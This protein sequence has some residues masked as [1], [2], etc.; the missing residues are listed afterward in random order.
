MNR[1]EVMRWLVGAAGLAAARPVLAQVPRR[2]RIRRV[3]IL[4]IS[5]QS[6]PDGRARLS[7]FLNAMKSMGWIDGRNI[8]YEYR[9]GASNAG[10]AAALAAELIASAPEVILV[11]G[12]PGVSALQKATRTIPV[13]FVVVTDPVGAGFVQ[14]QARPGANITGF[15]TFEPEIGG[16]WLELLKGI[17]PEIRRV[18]GILDPQFPGF[19]RVWNAVEAAAARSRIEL[20]ALPLRVAGDNIESAVGQFA[21]GSAA[22]L[23][24]LPTAVN[25]TAR[26]R[27]IALSAKHRLPAV[28]PFRHYAVEGGLMAYGFQ[29]VDLWRRSASYVDRILKGEMPA[30]LPVQS[31]TTYELVINR[32]TAKNIGLSVPKAMLVQADELID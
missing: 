16:K 10:R 17:A 5:G 14:S 20:T 22:G 25:N 6:D 24:A 30:D 8:Q 32:R 13:V 3:A 18:A 31:P 4:S 27:L 19:A 23:I 29:P 1:R 7:A 9:W 2:D 28:Y 11:N 15:S 12:T 21:N 26:T